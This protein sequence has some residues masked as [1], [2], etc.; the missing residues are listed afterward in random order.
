MAFIKIIANAIRRVW[1]FATAIVFIA[2]IIAF[3]VFALTIFMPDQVIGAINIV[4]G[5]FT[6]VGI[7]G[8]G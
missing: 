7:V 1:S 4:K 3:V 6:E 5:W 2:V 8:F